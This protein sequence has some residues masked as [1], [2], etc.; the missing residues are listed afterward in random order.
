MKVQ[1]IVQ[2]IN[3][4]WTYQVF[5]PDCF[6]RWK[7]INACFCRQCSHFQHS[8][9]D[10]SLSFWAVSLIVLQH[11]QWWWQVSTCLFIDLRCV[12]LGCRH[13]APTVFFVRFCIVKP[14]KS[15]SQ[16]AEPHTVYREMT[17]IIVWAMIYSLHCWNP[18]KIP[19]VTVTMNMCFFDRFWVKVCVFAPAMIK[20]R[21]SADWHSFSQTGYIPRH[22]LHIL[23]ETTH[24]HTFRRQWFM[25]KWKMC[26]IH[27]QTHI[28]THIGLIEQL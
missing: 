6:V 25:S 19:P 12:V 17:A 10:S 21:V 3:K 22:K 9:L 4:I 23:S 1:L 26:D 5:W 28:Q 2:V 13:L 15:W 24:T 18:S 27:T 20:R 16:K 7:K 11:M 14:I 8:G